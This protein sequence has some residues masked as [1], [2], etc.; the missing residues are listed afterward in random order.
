[1][2]EIAP[3]INFVTAAGHGG[4]KLDRAHNAKVPAY[5][6]E[7]GG[8]YEKNS[9]WAI[10]AII[11]PQCFTAEEGEQAKHILRNG[12]PDIYARFYNVPLMSLR[13]QSNVLDERIFQEEHKNDW[14]VVAEVKPGLYV[15]L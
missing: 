13:G 12:K 15:S 2:R 7:R 11:F 10:P 1:M 3:G 4:I 14:V 5:V 8:W 6:R 9:D